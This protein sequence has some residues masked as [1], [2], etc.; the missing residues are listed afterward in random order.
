MRARRRERRPHVRRA[1]AG[2]T[3]SRATSASS[4]SAAKTPRRISA[5]DGKRLIFQARATAARC[6][7]EFV[8]NVDGSDVAA[9]LDRLRQD[10]LRL[11]L[12]RR[13][14]DLLRLDARRRHDVPAEAR[15]VEGLRLGPRSVR[16]LHREPRRL[17]PQASHELRRLHGGRHAVARRTDDR[18]HVAQGRRSRHLH[19]ERRRLEHEAAHDAPGYDGG[20]FWSPDGKQHRLSRLASDRHRAHELS[21]SAA[22]SGSCA[23]IGWSSG[24]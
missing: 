11:L 2:E 1:E 17:G 8:M 6:D 16:H 10:D 13:P 3:P 24:S 12:R 19:D 23:R 4:P 21:G 14:Q 20:P 9:R 15:S 7:Q 5:H 18:L 22:S